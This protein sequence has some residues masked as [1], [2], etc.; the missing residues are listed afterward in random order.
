MLPALGDVRYLTALGVEVPDATPLV[1][2]LDDPGEPD[3]FDMEELGLTM[4]AGLVVKD[5]VIAEF[6][7]A[8]GGVAIDPMDAPPVELP[9]R[10]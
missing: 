1:A 7:M 9:A 10:V 5:V 8:E 6:F 2:L 4:A 3:E